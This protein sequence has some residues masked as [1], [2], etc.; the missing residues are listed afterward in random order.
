VKTGL[1]IFSL[2]N[3]VAIVTGGSQGIGLAISEV[4][5]S[6]GCNLVICSPEEEQLGEAAKKLK[7][8]GYNALPVYSDVTKKDMVLELVNR[9]ISEY[10]KIDILIN[11]AGINSDSLVVN[12]E[13]EQW[14]KVINVNLKGAFNCSKAVA[15][16]MIKQKKGKI[17]NIAS[18]SYK[19]SRGAVNYSA[20]KGGV[21]SLT[22]GLA[23]EWAD[24][25]IN[26]NCISPGVVN[27]H[28]FN[29]LPD[30]FKQKV[31]RKIPLKRL[32]E[33][34][35]IGNCVLFLVSEAAGFITG[36]HIIVDGGMTL[37][38]I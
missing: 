19:G 6:V 11:N 34:Y 13:E 35:D 37:G 15:P 33:P 31:I 29:N 32:A 24:F 4:L 10:G 26:V 12:M 30:K 16:H 9:T 25:N 17:V 21:I 1:S 2:E 3:Q 8:C 7:N 22:K 20:S 38:F 36:E 18:V 5:G 23:L 28:M 14:D 27:T